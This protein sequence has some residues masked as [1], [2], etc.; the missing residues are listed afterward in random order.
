MICEKDQQMAN[1]NT[2]ELRSFKHDINNQS[3]RL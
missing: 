1:T 2:A 3:K